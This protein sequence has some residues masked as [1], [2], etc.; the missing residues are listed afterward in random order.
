MTLPFEVELIIFRMV[1]E[2]KLA[3]VCK[4]LKKNMEEMNRNLNYFQT[5]VFY[6]YLLWDRVTPLLNPY[7]QQKIDRYVH[8]KKFL[9]CLSHLIRPKQH[10]IYS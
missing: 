4:E 7:C 5:H 10:I 2:L 1:H 9:R 3:D 8:Y 6:P